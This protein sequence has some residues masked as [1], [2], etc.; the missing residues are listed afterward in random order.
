MHEGMVDATSNAPINLYFDKTPSGMI[1]NRF[2]ND[3]NNI[4]TK[5][6]E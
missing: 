6:G 5:I 4:E 3:I 1:L 2:S